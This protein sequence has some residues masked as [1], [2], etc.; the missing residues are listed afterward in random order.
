MWDI[1][2]AVTLAVLTG[3]STYLGIYVTLKPPKSNSKKVR[4]KRSFV[5]ILAASVVLIFVQA[6]RANDNAKKLSASLQSIEHNTLTSRHTYIAFSD[7]LPVTNDPYFPFRVG[8][9]PTVAIQYMS[10]GGYPATNVLSENKLVLIQNPTFSDEEE[11]AFT[12]FTQHT[13]LAAGGALPAYSQSKRYNTTTLATPLT[14]EQVQQLNQNSLHLCALARV[15]WSDET[16]QFCTTY[17]RCGVKD[18]G[19]KYFVYD[20]RVIGTKYN[21]EHPCTYKSIQ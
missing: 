17:F 8:E 14:S 15:L 3:L 20:W 18:N 12:E 6:D 19:N 10:A 7:P 2:I 1:F 5:T 9:R 11:R 21:D 4:Y 13:G 16:G